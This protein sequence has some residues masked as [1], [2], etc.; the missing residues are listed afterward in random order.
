[1][2]VFGEVEW[3]FVAGMMS[4]IWVDTQTAA[5]LEFLKLC[6]GILNLCFHAL[7][8]LRDVVVFCNPSHLSA[9][10]HD[11]LFDLSSFRDV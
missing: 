10:S 8:F 9:I 4:T 11:P 3:S 5:S 7:N 1:M 2:V 6:R